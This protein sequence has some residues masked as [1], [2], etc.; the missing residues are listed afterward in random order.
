MIKRDKSILNYFKFSARI[1]TL[2]LFYTCFGSYSYGENDQGQDSLSGLYEYNL[3]YI[4]SST[5]I[6]PKYKYVMEE[7]VELLQE[8]PTTKIHIRGHVCC[9]PNKRISRKRARKVYQFF[10]KNDIAA[11]RLSYEG[12]SDEIPLAYPE[13]TEE[14][15]I[16]NRRVD[17]L[18]TNNK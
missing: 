17:F 10:L 8:N 11:E 5:T 15:E 4:G 18:L 13:K 12:Y 9:G 7:L 14:D 1:C 2:I 3:R 16:K 6:D